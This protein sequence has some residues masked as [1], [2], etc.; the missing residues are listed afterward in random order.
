M[1]YFRI[2][3]VL[4]GVGLACAPFWLVGVQRV[5]AAETINSE[6]VEAVSSPVPLPAVTAKDGDTIIDGANLNAAD[7]RQE[8]Q[9]LLDE[10]LGLATKELNK[11]STFYPF[12]AGLTPSGKVELVGIPTNKERPDPK[13]TIKA[14]RK[15]AKQLAH[16]KRFRALALY[17]DFVAE[18]K[19]TAIK[20]PG[21]RV[22]LEHER[23][24]ALSV[25][26][27]YFIHSDNRITL[28]TPQFMPL[29]PSAF[30]AKK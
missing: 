16:K 23:P 30:V 18:R 12:L 9:Y 6:S 27:P 28:M 2:L 25:F 22:E 7:A 10:T 24:D 3:Q 8:M 14:L 21:I 15:A 17:V 20:Q 29:K 4:V 11:T 5:Y 1:I 26:I 13:T 19:D